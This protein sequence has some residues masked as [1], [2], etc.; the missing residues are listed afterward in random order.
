MP[1]RDLG[2]FPF[3]GTSIDVVAIVASAY[4]MDAIGRVLEGLPGDFRAAV[5]A[6][7]HLPARFPSRLA[8]LLSARTA[9][10]VHWARPVAVLVPRH[11]YV[12][13]P[14]RH[15]LV[16]SEGRLTFTDTPNVRHARPAGDV[17]FASLARSCGPR[18]AA[19]VL[20]GADANGADGVRYVKAGG[21]LVVVQDPATAGHPAMPEAAIATGCV[22]YVLP[23]DHIGPLLDWA[24]RANHQKRKAEMEPV[25]Q[26]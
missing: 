10:R 12:V 3:P 9:L 15:V 4:G 8:D 17:L 26:S 18:S 6:I 11:A 2:G 13:G 1:T 5:V 25:A 14:G 20:T 7:Q 19:A 16:T 21:G 23:L 24:A 22:G